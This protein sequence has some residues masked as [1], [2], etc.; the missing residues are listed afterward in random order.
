MN[1][2]IKESAVRKHIESLADKG[3]VRVDRMIYRH[4]DIMVEHEVEK[5]VSQN[6]GKRFATKTIKLCS[7]GDM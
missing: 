7:D 2:Y 3:T 5:I 1:T 6:K 4:L